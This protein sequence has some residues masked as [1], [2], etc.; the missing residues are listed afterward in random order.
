MAADLVAASSC[1]ASMLL[2]Q[3]GNCQLHV[4]GE[5]PVVIDRQDGKRLKGNAGVDLAH[6]RRKALDER[7]AR[8]TWPP[9][10]RSRRPAPRPRRPAPAPPTRHQ[11]SPWHIPGRAVRSCRSRGTPGRSRGTGCGPQTAH[12]QCVLR[13]PERRRPNAR[14]HRRVRSRRRPVRRELRPLRERAARLRPV[15]SSRRS[16]VRWRAGLSRRQGLSAG[17]AHSDCRRHRRVAGRDPCLVSHRALVPYRFGELAHD[18]IGAEDD[19]RQP[20]TGTTSM[21]ASRSSAL[22]ARTPTAPGPRSG[23]QPTPSSIA[24]IV[25]PSPQR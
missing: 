2:A 16:A 25:T 11:G 5:H 3:S 6:E 10:A 7:D 22:S 8:P 15:D 9:G 4:L 17:P 18:A 14:R 24:S 13:R 12:P 19:R 21:S 1:S 23:A 20:L